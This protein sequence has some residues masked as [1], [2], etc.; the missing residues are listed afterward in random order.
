[1]EKESWRVTDWLA[2]NNIQPVLSFPLSH[3]FSTS[4]YLSFFLFPHIHLPVYPMD[5]KKTGRETSM[6]TD[7]HTA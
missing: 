4:L 1:M 6:C 7:G 2:G 3:S 5:I